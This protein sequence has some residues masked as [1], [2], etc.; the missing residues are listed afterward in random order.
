M[1]A[2]SIFL[3]LLKLQRFFPINDKLNLLYISE[4]NNY[5]NTKFLTQYQNSTLIR[6]LDFGENRKS[7]SGVG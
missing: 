1:Y 4:N 3:F 2:N 6:F 7:G 5:R